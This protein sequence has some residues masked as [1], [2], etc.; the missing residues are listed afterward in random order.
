MFLPEVSCPRGGSWTTSRS[1][2]HASVGGC[3]KAGRRCVLAPVT[4]R[5]ASTLPAQ[6]HAERQRESP[7]QG[8]GQVPKDR[9]LFG[10]NRVVSSTCA[11]VAEFNSG[12]EATMR[13]LCSVIGVTP[14]LRLLGS[15][16]KVD[17]R[18]CQQ[19][20]RQVAASSKAASQPRR[21]LLERLLD[22]WLDV[23]AELPVLLRQNRRQLI[24]LLAASR[25][26]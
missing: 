16:E 19:A 10:I 11:A 17:I 23:L 4:R 24:M 2:W 6:R 9:V 14:G 25:L 5:P 21:R 13:H 8:L 15:A 22:A 20:E 18:R 1:C 26:A 3:C 7:L 12:V